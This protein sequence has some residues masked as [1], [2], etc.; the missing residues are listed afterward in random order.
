MRKI[1]FLIT[2]ISLIGCGGVSIEDKLPLP[3][4]FEPSYQIVKKEDISYKYDGLDIFR[5]SY[6]IIVPSYLSEKNIKNNCRHLVR[7]EQQHTAARNVSIF[8]Y[9][10][11]SEITG[12][13]TVAMYEFCPYGDWSRTDETYSTI[14]ENYE[15]NFKTR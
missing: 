8:V 5:Y 4:D 12:S 2:L 15:E 11:A 9:Y 13:Y 6:R 3:D 10:N 1:F 14:T 7:T